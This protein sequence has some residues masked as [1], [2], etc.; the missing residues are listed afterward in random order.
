MRGKYADEIKAGDS[1]VS[2][3]RTITDTDVVMFTSMTWINDPIFTDDVF[4]SRTLFG[5]RAVPGPLLLAYSLGLTEELVYG[6]T[7]AAMGIDKVRFTAPVKP[8]DTIHVRSSVASHRESTSRPG[9]AIVVFEHAVYAEGGD[10]PA[11]TFQRTML[12]GTRFYV[13]ALASDAGARR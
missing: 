12:V 13:E 9:T 2:H 4:A 3:R 1:F 5:R 7:L 6:T 10:A 11:C 8:G